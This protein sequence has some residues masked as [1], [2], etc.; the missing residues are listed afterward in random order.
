MKKMCERT[1]EIIALG[2]ELSMLEREHIDGCTSCNSLME[3]YQLLTLLVSEL[4]DS[5]VPDGFADAVMKKI[6]MEEQAVED[7]GML[8]ISRFFEKL[9]MIPSVQYLAFGFGGV[10]SILNL[11]KFVFYVLIPI[12]GNL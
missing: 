6:E 12:N 5:D 2:S 3:E 7:N 9:M 11:I 8:G 10:V 4:A 1:Q